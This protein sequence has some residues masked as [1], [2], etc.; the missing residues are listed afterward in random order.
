MHCITSSTIEQLRVKTLTLNCFSIE[1]FCKSTSILERSCLQAR[2]LSVTG[3]AWLWALL[4]LLLAAALATKQLDN[5]AFFDDEPDS[6]YTAGINNAGPSNLGEVW[7]FIT[8]KDP[9]PDPGL[10]ATALHLGTHRWLERTCHP[11]VVPFRRHAGAR[12]G[13]PRRPR[14]LQPSDWPRCR[15]DA[16]NVGSLPCLHGVRARLHDGCAFHRADPVELLARRPSSAIHQAPARRPACCWA[17][18]ACSTR[19]ILARCS[20]PRWASFTCSSSRRS[21]AGGE[22]CYLSAWQQWSPRCSCPAF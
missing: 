7:E 9:R 19:I 15:P 3:R 4:P 11:G 16:G 14:F 22:L 13:L 1:N 21:A 2:A 6:L 8:E 12:V 10:D 5:R 17:A 18:S 20:C